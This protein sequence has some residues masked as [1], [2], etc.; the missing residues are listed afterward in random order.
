LVSCLYHHVSILKLT[1]HNAYTEY[2]TTGSMPKPTPAEEDWCSP[3]LERTEWYD[4]LD[5]TSRVE[6]FSC[7]WGVMEYL[8]RDVTVSE[9]DVAGAGIEAQSEA[10]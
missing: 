3:K 8:S 2:L 10:V 9:S 1:I 6:A 4:L 7:I 5:Q